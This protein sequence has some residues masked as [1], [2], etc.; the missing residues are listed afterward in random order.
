[1]EVTESSEGSQRS[2]KKKKGPKSQDKK[3]LAGKK[4]K[5]A[6]RQS[7]ARQK[8]MSATRPHSIVHED[9][10]HPIKEDER[11]NIVVHEVTKQSSRRSRK[12][13]T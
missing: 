11:E 1:M 5:S 12:L 7:T 10:M 8:A 13:S 3:S 9:E 4:S 6:S 2:G